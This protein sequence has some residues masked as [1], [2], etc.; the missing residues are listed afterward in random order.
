M[1][2]AREEIISMAKDAGAYEIRENCLGVYPWACEFEIDQLERFAALVAEAAKQAMQQ[3][4]WQ[5]I[6]TAPKD[7]SYIRVY[8]P[9][10]DEVESCAWWN[11]DEYAKKPLPFWSRTD[12]I[13]TSN[14]RQNPPTHWM[15]ISTKKPKPKVTE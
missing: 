14:S 6:E 1:N 3:D 7:G 4:E 5:P 13:G 9:T 10:W 12:C 11:A 8:P 2:L 15:P